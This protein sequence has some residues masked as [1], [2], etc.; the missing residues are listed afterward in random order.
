MAIKKKQIEEEAQKY[1][2]SKTPSKFTS[3]TPDIDKQLLSTNLKNPQHLEVI[4]NRYKEAGLF[5]GKNIPSKFKNAEHFRKVV[6]AVFKK[7]IAKDK[8]KIDAL[9]DKNAK[10]RH[11]EKIKRGILNRIIQSDAKRQLTAQGIDWANDP[12]L[13]D[14]IDNLKYKGLP[15]KAGSKGISYNS[16]Q[17]SDKVLDT[18]VD[19][20]NDHEIPDPNDP[21][22]K[23]KIKP[24]TE[25]AGKKW[26]KNA[27]AEWRKWGEINRA[28]KA[29]YGIDFDIGHFVPSALGGPNVGANAATEL[30]WNRVNEEGVEILG[31][32]PKGKK[33]G[34]KISQ[35]ANEL[36]VPESY[37]Q[38]FLNKQI[39]VS[40]KGVSLIEEAVGPSA[41]DMQRVANAGDIDEQIKAADKLAAT[42]RSKTDDAAQ[43]LVEVENLKKQGIIPPETTVIGDGSTKPQIE[44]FND[45]KKYS[46]AERSLPGY[47]IKDSKFVKKVTQPT[48]KGILQGIVR[49]G[50]TIF[51][52]T[53]NNKAVKQVIDSG[54]KVIGGLPKP[55][56][57]VVK[58]APIIGSIDDLALLATPFYNKEVSKEQEKIDMTKAI[59]G[60][61]GLASLKFPQTW[62][63][64]AMMWGVGEMKQQ[65]LDRKNQ[66]KQD[67][68]LWYMQK[69]IQA[70]D[71][72][73]MPTNATLGADTR[74][75]GRFKR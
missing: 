25:E 48:T 3:K 42:T 57:K 29:K 22:G 34:L 27:R 15:L 6:D 8:K 21:T 60:G 9:V 55:I 4:F 28:L 18:I 65:Q 45:L 69:Y 58:E 71:E 50:K 36:H 35:I 68:D 54:T 33:P 59:G 2:K 26:A 64:S 13:K 49:D 39:G 37:L 38:D 70:T 19:W 52:T 74:R 14:K 30:T 61:L 62:L 46:S 51:E 73:G 75:T 72:E 44:D 10:K 11:I 56:K 43:L 31:N 66:R 24:F 16:R 53:V 5:S 41:G 67:L 7:E 32:R 17:F 20:A 47:E 12:M 40:G 23:T 63:P 1:V